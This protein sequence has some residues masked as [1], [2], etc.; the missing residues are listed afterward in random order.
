MTIDYSIIQKIKKNLSFSRVNCKMENHKEKLK[1]KEQN[2]IWN[3]KKMLF[4]VSQQ[5]HFCLLCL[6]AIK[7][8]LL[9]H[10]KAVATALVAHT[11]SN[12]IRNAQYFHCRHFIYFASR[13]FDWLNATAI[14]LKI[15]LI[16]KNK[17]FWYLLS[18]FQW[19]LLRYTVE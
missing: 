16:H 11:A 3:I 9:C 5:P 17:C 12:N 15:N 14:F 6:E 2:L 18:T 8:M 10:T 4:F 1:N 13:D 7:S 19:T